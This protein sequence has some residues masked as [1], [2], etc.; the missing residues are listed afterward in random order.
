MRIFLLAL[1]P[2]FDAH[3]LNLELSW[4]GW[5]GWSFIQ[6]GTWIFVGIQKYIV[7]IEIHID[8]LL[9]ATKLHFSRIR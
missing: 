6:F 4:L 1:A 7:G 5:F 9:I 3:R 2:Y 8:W